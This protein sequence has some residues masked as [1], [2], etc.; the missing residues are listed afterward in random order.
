MIATST[1]LLLHLRWFA[2]EDGMLARDAGEKEDRVIVSGRAEIA[3]Q[4]LRS[5]RRAALLDRQV[6]DAALAH[7][8]AEPLQIEW[9]RVRD[10]VRGREGRRGQY[11][12]RDV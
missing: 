6:A 5:E 2:D 1:H 3:Q 4:A 12:A 8:G 10:F 11:V 7:V 9:K